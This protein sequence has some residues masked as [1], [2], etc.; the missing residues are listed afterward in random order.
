MPASIGTK[1]LKYKSV[2]SPYSFLL[3]LSYCS[4][5]GYEKEGFRGH[6]YLLE[7]GEYQD[8]RVWGGHNSELRSVRL[9]KA[10]SFSEETEKK[11]SE[12]LSLDVILKCLGK[13]LD[14][15]GTKK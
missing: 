8:W 9:I 10:V 7:E 15:E 11:N 6:Q 4:W 13:I 14:Q 2:P 5:V 12:Q 3:S 1:G